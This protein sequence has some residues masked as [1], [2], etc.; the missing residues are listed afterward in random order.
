MQDANI[1][2]ILTIDDE[3]YIRK[4]IRSYLEDHGFEVFEAENGRVGVEMFHQVRPDLVLL[5]LRMPELDGLQVLEILRD[6]SPETPL[7]VAS[8]TGSIDSVVQALHLGAWDYILKPVQD[9]NVLIHSVTKCLKES[10]LQMENRAYQE[11]L[12]D[13]VRER[14]RKLR[15]S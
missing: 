1:G 14:T 15:E 7:I 5:D 11:R 3:A 6:Q 13:L 10:R 12:E 8:G 4:S 9:M 2:R